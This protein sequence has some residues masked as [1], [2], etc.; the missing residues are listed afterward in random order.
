MNNDLISREALKKEVEKYLEKRQDVIVWE[1]DIYN[2]IDNAPTVE[3]PENTINCVLTMFG[4]CSYNKTGC[5]DC[6]IKDKIRKALEERPQGDITEEWAIDKLHETGW[7][8]LHDMEM[9]ERQTGIEREVIGYEGLYSV[10][11]FGTVRNVSSGKIIEHYVNEYG[12]HNVYLYKDGEKKGKRVNRLVAM[13]FI[14]NP[15]DKPQVNHIDGNKDNNNV[16]NLEWVTNKENSV[17][18]GR[19]GLYGNGQVKIVETCEVFPNVSSLARYIKVDSSNIYKCLQGKRNKVR[20]YHFER[21]GADM[22][23]KEAENELCKEDETKR[24]K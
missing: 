20:G 1:S 15:L 22:R 7:L 18:A 2:I 24:L 12:Y 14:P 5:S 3:V 21:V 8:P 9:T 16:W 13:A 23:G 11:I 4:E 17:H 10:D 19:L 6:E